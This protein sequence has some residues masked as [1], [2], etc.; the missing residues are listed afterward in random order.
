M[1]FTSSGRAVRNLTENDAHAEQ[2]DRRYHQRYAE[3]VELVGIL[4]QLDY[5]AEYHKADDGGY[6]LHVRRPLVLPRQ[7]YR[8]YARQ[9][10]RQ[11]LQLKRRS[12]ESEVADDEHSPVDSRHD[13]EDD[14]RRKEILSVVPVNRLDGH[15][16]V[17]ER[18]HQHQLPRFDGGLL[19]G[20]LEE[21]A[22]AQLLVVFLAAQKLEIGVADADYVVDIYLRSALGA[23]SVD[24][25]AVKAL[26][27][28]DEPSLVAPQKYGVNL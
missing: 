5:R 13:A 16:E 3:A 26:G 27:I 23:P 20:I 10:Q 9:K 28:V 14:K 8:A 6:N 2:S 7:Q 25:G 11:S 18:Y 4:N 19:R 15:E 21:P 22:R 12:A 1:T 17:E 24:E